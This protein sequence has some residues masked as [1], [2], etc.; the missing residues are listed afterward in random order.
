MVQL[1]AAFGLS[2]AEARLAL[3]LSAGASLASMAK[4]F[5]VKLSTIRS[6]LQQVFEK[7]GTSRQAQLV[8][9]LLSHGYVG[10]NEPVSESDWGERKLQHGGTLD[11][12]LAGRMA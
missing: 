5:D 8:A 12:I 11:R 7:T 2:K 9:L 6:Q 3:H 10:P 4:A 1:R